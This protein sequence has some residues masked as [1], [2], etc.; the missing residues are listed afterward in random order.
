[1]HSDGSLRAQP[2]DAIFKDVLGKKHGQVAQIVL[3]DAGNAVSTIAFA[4]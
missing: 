4:S 1:M 2:R 3:Q